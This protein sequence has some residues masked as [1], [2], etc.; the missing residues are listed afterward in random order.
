MVIASENQTFK[1]QW[2]AERMLKHRRG[3]YRTKSVFALFINIGL[4][5]FEVSFK[6][7]ATGAAPG[8]EGGGKFEL[9]GQLDRQAGLRKSGGK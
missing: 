9:E 4:W 6:A 5:N 3:A 8:D 7:P 1:R 2:T